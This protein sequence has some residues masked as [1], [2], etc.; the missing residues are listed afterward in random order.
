MYG[1]IAI[2]PPINILKKRLLFFLLRVINFVRKGIFVLK[3]K[4]AILLLKVSDLPV[5]TISGML[6][7]YDDAYFYKIFKKTYNITPSEYRKICTK[8]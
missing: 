8:K 7:F 5:S 3:H 2:P 1:C 4:K 6:G